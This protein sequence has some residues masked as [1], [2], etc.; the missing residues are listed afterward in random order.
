MRP[1]RR[2]LAII[3]AATLSGCAFLGFEEEDRAG[4]PPPGLFPE[5]DFG[6]GEFADPEPE[7][8]TDF[9][10]PVFIEP[11]DDA[12]IA[13]PD[14]DFARFD[15]PGAD[16]PPPLDYALRDRPA[17][18]EPTYTP[19]AAPNVAAPRAHAAYL[20]FVA[21]R[22]EAEAYFD[23]LWAAHG[24][25]LAGAQPYVSAAP[26]PNTGAPA[27]HIYAVDVSQAQA[28]ALCDALAAT[29]TPCQTIAR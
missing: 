23:W 17:R 24:D 28:Q 11:D 2:L 3:A 13:G 25:R 8:A 26:D 27:V 19:P 18:I 7:P 4:G 14:S 29:Q 9:A 1:S 10:A 5:S 15:G 16:A 6:E 12:F 21:E 20:G 22:A